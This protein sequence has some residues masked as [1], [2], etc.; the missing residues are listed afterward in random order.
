MLEGMHRVMSDDFPTVFP[1]E[2]RQG[3]IAAVN[4]VKKLTLP[5][6]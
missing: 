2:Y 4:E 5:K 3:F 6:L 1:K